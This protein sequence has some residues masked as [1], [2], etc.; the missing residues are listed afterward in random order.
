MHVKTRT[1]EDFIVFTEI[2]L[3]LQEDDRTTSNKDTIVKPFKLKDIPIDKL[4]ISSDTKIRNNE[5]IETPKGTT[6]ECTLDRSKINKN[7]SIGRG[8]FRMY[9]MQRK[10]EMSEK[11]FMNSQS[12]NIY[13][14]KFFVIITKLIL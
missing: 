13:Y 3:F 12:G 9:E 1:D 10:L 5:T 2:H 7:S 6:T 11:K 8:T 14:I 4:S